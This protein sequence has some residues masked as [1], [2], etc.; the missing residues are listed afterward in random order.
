MNVDEP[1]VGNN[2]GEHS[3]SIIGFCEGYII[4]Y[5]SECYQCHKEIAHYID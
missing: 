3:W 1:C 4:W 5:C 2:K